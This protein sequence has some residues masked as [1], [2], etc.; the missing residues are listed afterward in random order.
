MKDGELIL[1][2]GQQIIDLKADNAK[3][4]EA[5]EFYGD[6]QTYDAV[7]IDGEIIDGID[8]RDAPA[9]RRAR[10]VLEETSNGRE[11]RTETDAPR[12]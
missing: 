11:P 4:R 8:Y 6:E 12:S 1:N 7:V 3:L 5:L 2:L 10:A 9:G